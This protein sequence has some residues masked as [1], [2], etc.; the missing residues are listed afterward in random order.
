MLQQMG[1]NENQD[2]E[3]DIPV[4]KYATEKHVACV[5]LLDIS[6]SMVQNNAIGQLNEG[7]RVFKEQTL[8]SLD[9]HAKACIDVAV[10]T[11][12]DKI[13]LIQ[14][15]TP[16]ED[17]N[18]PVLQASGLTAM[19]GAL[20]M[21]MDLITKQKKLYNAA[22]TPY[23]R[24]WLFCI[25]DGAPNDDYVPH[26]KRLRWMEDNK[27]AVAY[28]V[29]VDGFRADIMQTIFKPEN[30]YGLKNCDFTSL[31]KFVSSSLDA[32]RNSAA[33]TGALNVETPESMFRVPLD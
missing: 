5:F 13:D 9:K 6:G 28:C 24:P 21:G 11:F 22:G 23:F 19:G 30:I 16:V 33:E 10:I 12:N 17:M 2:N 25:T 29:G 31:F 27:K 26:A 15:F 18:I 7:L 3:F 20:D 4:V 1:F 14:G 8:A 32:L